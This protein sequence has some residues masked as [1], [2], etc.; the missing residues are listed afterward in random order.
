MIQ[1]TTC[2]VC[3]DPLELEV[4]EGTE[5]I[6]PL[7]KLLSMATCHRCMVVQRRA[8]YSDNRPPNP[9]QKMPYKD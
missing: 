7:K 6:V 3:G 4:P 2:Q 9:Q 5:D 8:K 1:K